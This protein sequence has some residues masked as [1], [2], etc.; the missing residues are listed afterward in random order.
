LGQ[1]KQLAT[2]VKANVDFKPVFVVEKVATLIEY[3][4]ACPQDVQRRSYTSTLY[5]A[6]FNHDTFIAPMIIAIRIRIWVLL[7]EK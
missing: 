5:P 3:L 4:T 7:G 6:I 2:F 1:K